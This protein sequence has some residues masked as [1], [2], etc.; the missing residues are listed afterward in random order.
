MVMP[1]NGLRFGFGAAADPA[2]DGDADA[3]APVETS[4]LLAAIG[5]C[6]KP[7]VTAGGGLAEAAAPGGAVGLFPIPAAARE[8][9]PISIPVSF[10]M[11]QGLVRAKLRSA[12][13]PRLRESL[14][15]AQAA[16]AWES[17]RDG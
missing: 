16:P 14:S 9:R 6:P 11:P 15:S 13:A 10:L 2:P 4:L 5:F 17:A 12:P 1:E 8:G 3:A 7:T